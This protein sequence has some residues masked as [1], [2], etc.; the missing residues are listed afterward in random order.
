MLRSPVASGAS[1]LIAEDE[2]VDRALYR[3]SIDRVID[4]AAVVEA[5]TVERAL[6][7]VA[8]TRFDL[9]LVDIALGDQSDGGIAV[10]S[11]LSAQPHTA[12][13]MISGLDPAV[14][15]PRLFARDIW[16]Y[17]EK[18]VDEPSL[19]AVIARLMA[20]PTADRNPSS[21]AITIDGLEWDGDLSSEPLWQGSPLGLSQTERRLLAELVLAPDRLARREVLFDCFVRWDRDPRDLRTS[22]AT[23]IYRLRRAFQRIDPTFDRIE[24]V[25]GVGYLWREH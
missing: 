15:R 1:I 22:L 2:S 8:A 6:R 7:A 16:D 12:L 9:A 5:E 3:R 11:A 18:P 19:A 4:A 25:G 24:A 13:V 10:A 14:Y 23:S 21:G 17:F 20:R